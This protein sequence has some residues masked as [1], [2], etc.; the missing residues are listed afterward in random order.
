M[1]YLIGD[2]TISSQDPGFQAS[3][4]T[5]HEKSL[6]PLC[7]C[8]EGGLPMYTAHAFGR[9]LLKR[10]PGTGEKHDKDC[11]SFETPAENSGLGELVAGG[12]ITENPED[13]TTLLKLDFRLTTRGGTQQKIARASEQTSARTDGKKLTLRGLL[14]VL[15]IESKINYWAPGFSGKRKCAGSYCRVSRR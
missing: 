11:G 13:G 5:A 9:Y 15:W 3:L 14:H 1:D 10:M 8:V 6:R 7:C 2:Q 12:A 4:K